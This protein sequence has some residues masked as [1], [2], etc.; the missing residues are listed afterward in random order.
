MVEGDFTRHGP[1]GNRAVV[2]QKGVAV[3]AVDKGN[4]KHFRAVQRLLHTVADAMI[5]V[6]RLDEGERDVGLVDEDIVGSSGNPTLYHF[7]A[8]DDPAFGEV[9][10]LPH[11]R[12]QV[13]LVPIRADQRRRDELG[14]NLCFGQCLLVHRSI[15]WR[16]AM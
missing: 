3:G 15:S 7:P 2:F 14:A 9:D 10:L 5:V 12:H 6:L 13:P 8:N 4:I 1:G 11:L 16:S